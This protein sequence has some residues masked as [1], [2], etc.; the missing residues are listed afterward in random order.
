M[1]SD[2][3]TEYWQTKYYI[4]VLII[5]VIHIEGDDSEAWTHQH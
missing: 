1:V 3:S 2:E 4:P 5:A